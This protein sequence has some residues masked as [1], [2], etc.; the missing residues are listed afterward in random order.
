MRGDDRQERVLSCYVSR[1]AGIPA[2]HP[3]RP[4]LPMVDMVPIE[5]SPRFVDLY[6]R[7]GWHSIPPERLL[8][9]LLLQV[10][11]TFRSERLVIGQL[12]YSILF[13]WFVCLHIGDAVWDATAFPK[14][15]T[16][17]APEPL[18]RAS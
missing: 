8:R 12:I 2:G 16:A 11:Y 10:L 6:A 4:I 17:S 18:P 7:T 1:E 15:G 9:A 5:L 13:R 3:P 14:T